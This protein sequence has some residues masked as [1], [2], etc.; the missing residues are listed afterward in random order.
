MAGSQ[1]SVVDACTR[2]G[3]GGSPTAVIID[4][5]TLTDD[6]RSAIA[7]TTG[8]SHAAFVDTSTS[9]APTVRFFTTAGE[10]NNCGHG[11]IAAQAVLL[12]R[13][14]AHQHQGYQCTGDRTFATT[15]IRRPDGIEAWFD[16]GIIEL[17]DCATDGAII[18]ALGLRPGDIIGDDLRVASPGTQRLLVPV[19]ERRTLLSIRPDLD[20]LAL[21]CRRLG[22][23]GC[24]AYALS[25]RTNTAL[26]RM[27]APAIGVDEDIVNANS[28]G[29][30][31]AH[32]LHTGRNSSIEVHQ[33]DTLGRPST[34]FATATHTTDGIAARIGGLVH[35]PEQQH[36]D[37]V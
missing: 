12:Q 6:E 37:T 1:V 14:G 7:R 4:D 21:E 15:A 29:C 5:H 31:A 23:L 10:L 16:Q 22:Y 35:H 19:R 13:R 28:A 2:N 33:G 20:R 26:A 25:P 27:F 11:T 32:L 3:G 9:G 17:Q 36:P 30:L 8:T 24:F 18:T 34:V